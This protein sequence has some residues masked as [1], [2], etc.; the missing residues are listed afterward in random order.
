[1]QIFYR[2]PSSV[3]VS[4]KKVSHQALFCPFDLFTAPSSS[5]RNGK[6]LKNVGLTARTLQDLKL[7]SKKKR[8]DTDHRIHPIRVDVISSE[9]MCLHANLWQF[10]NCLLEGLLAPIYNE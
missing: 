5:V 8:S 2:Q 6:K 1:M 4:L 10:Y 7:K 3:T 9:E